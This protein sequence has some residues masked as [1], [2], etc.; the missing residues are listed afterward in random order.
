MKSAVALKARRRLDE[1]L[2]TLRKNV[3]FDVPAKGWVRSIR[4]ALGM[5]GA[6]LARRLGTTPQ[7]VDALERSEASGSVK[8]ATLKRAAE[9]LDC[10]LVYALVPNRPLEEM[11]RIR[12]RTLAL[13]ELAGVELTMKLENQAVDQSEMEQRIDDYITEHVRLREIWD[14]H[15]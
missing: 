2:K 12:A 1:R 8:L 5:T 3:D 13:K 11:V 15:R 10:R 9:A 14:E 7:S 4:D 6:Q